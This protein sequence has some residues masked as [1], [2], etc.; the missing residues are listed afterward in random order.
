MPQQ[1]VLAKHYLANKHRTC[2][3]MAGDSLKTVKSYAALEHKMFLKCNT[4]P[5]VQDESESTNLKPHLLFWVREYEG[6][7]S[8]KEP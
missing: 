3:F 5:A 6:D 1:D 2:R 8:R 4:R 7:V